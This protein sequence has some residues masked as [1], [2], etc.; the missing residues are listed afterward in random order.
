MNCFIKL[1]FILC[2][3]YSQF[4]FADEILIEK[5]DV[6]AFIQ[7]MQDKHHYSK[8]TL[9]SLFKSVKPQPQVI[10]NMNHPL[11]KETW[12]LYQRV[13]IEDDHI[14]QGADFRK[15]YHRSL[16]RAEKK[17]GIPGSII[18]AT[19]GVE[20]LYG[21]R[22]GNYRVIDSLSNLSFSDQPR[23]RYFR[24]ELEHFLLLSREQR[25]DPFKIQGSYAGAIGAPQFMPSSYRHF[26]TSF[27][28]KARIDLVHNTQDAIASVANYYKVHGWQSPHFVAVQVTVKGQ[29]YQKLLNDSAAPSITSADFARYGLRPERKILKGYRVK[30]IEL[31]GLK[32]KEHWL[33]FH[34]FDVIKRYN[35]SDLYAMAVYQLSRN[36]LTYKKEKK[37]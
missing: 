1:V 19:L 34:D 4:A 33:V 22:S 21:K 28:K 9:L 31:E 24:G 25:L 11:E 5:P 36:I 7:H 6:Q 26:A 32:G 18:I 10:E 8:K 16:V 3:F 14:S 15:K 27:S 35:R 30:L 20:T 23:A 12:K 37:S 2:L 13:F 17:Y 29:A